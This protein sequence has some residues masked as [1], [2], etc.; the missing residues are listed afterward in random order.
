M[1]IAALAAL[2]T[3]DAVADAA[4][5]IAGSTA[6]A[7]TRAACRGLADAEL[8]VAAHRL[9]TLAADATTTPDEREILGAAAARC[10][11]GAMPSGGEA[12]TS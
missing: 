2:T 12:S 7:W 4:T 9:L 10:A 5:D 1:P 8:R 6:D 3:G 11:R